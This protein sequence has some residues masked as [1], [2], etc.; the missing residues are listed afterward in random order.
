M[1]LRVP[2]RREEDHVLGVPGTAAAVVGI[3]QVDR[4]AARGGDLP[5]LSVG[6]ERDRVVVVGP[7]RRYRPVGTREPAGIGS[8][9]RTHPERRPSF[10]TAGRENKAPAVRGEGRWPSLQ[11]HELEGR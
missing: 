9:Q 10:S 2:P 3:A 1:D 4:G 8:V 5:E 6:E 11:T 7:E